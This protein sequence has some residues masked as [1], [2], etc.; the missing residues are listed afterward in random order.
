VPRP[1]S[2]ATAK[3]LRLLGRTADAFVAAAIAVIGAVWVLLADEPTPALIGVVPVLIVLAQAGAPLNG[4]GLDGAGIDR[5]RLLPLHGSE[6]LASKNLAFGAL[7]L[8]QLSPLV[9]TA[10]WCFG[11]LAATTLVFGLLAYALAAVLIGNF[12][13]THATA[14]RDFHGVETIEQAG[15][16]LP[17]T[18]LLVAWIPP[19]ALAALAAPHGGPATACAELA[20]VGLLAAVYARALP[21]AGGELEASFDDLRERLAR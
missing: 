3:E 21:R 16:I 18:A 4:F 1:I 12:T 10:A 8:F 20:L 19:A 11:V 9:V 5:Y 7:L 2:I 13:S 17:V 15:G 6:V 14:P